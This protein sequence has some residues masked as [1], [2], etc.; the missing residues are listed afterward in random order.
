MTYL[1]EKI[2]SAIK[3]QVANLDREPTVFVYKV[4]YD[5]VDEA[6]TTYFKRAVFIGIDKSNRNYLSQVSYFSNILNE[7]WVK[8][9]GGYGDEYI[10]NVAPHRAVI[11]TETHLNEYTG[12]ADVVYLVDFEEDLNEV[13]YK[14]ETNLKEDRSWIARDMFAKVNEQKREDKVGD[15]IKEIENLPIED[16]KELL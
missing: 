11:D 15:L 6:D 16:L 8:K 9:I 7:P 10:D 1:A 12:K 4:N 14:R 5:L 3:K 2:Q 13:F